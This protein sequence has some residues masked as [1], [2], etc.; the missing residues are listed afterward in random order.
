MAEI[1]AVPENGL[2][3]V[4]TFSGCGGGCL[5]LKMAGFRI[6]W[7]SEFVPAA[8]ETYRANHAGVPVSTKDIREVNAE[9]ILAEAELAPGEVD[10][11]EGSP[12]CSSFSPSGSGVHHWGETKAYSDVEQRSD[13]LFFEF[14]RILGELRPRAF[15]AENVSGLVRGVSK[16]YFK[17]IHAALEAC[18]YRVEAR[19][20]DAQWLG[21]PQVR[22]RVIFV[23]LRDDLALD[24]VFPAPLAYRYSLRDAIGD[25]IPDPTLPSTSFAHYAIYD[26]WKRMPLGKA[27]RLYQ[28]LVRPRMDEPCP[29]VTQRG[30][31]GGVACVVHPYEARK[32]TIPELRRISGFPDDFV[33]TGSYPQQYERLGRAVPPPMM[34]AVARGIAGLLGG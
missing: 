13:D 25:G 29:T 26:E 6:A 7:A 8:A 10:L 16:G 21:V 11:L 28:N 30:G 17:R 19:M 24:P 4:S 22:R 12:P 20:L 33:L 14:A 1:E 5:G 15:V 32:F 2:V 9:E 31:G 3:V 18:G 27:S 23:G 34:A